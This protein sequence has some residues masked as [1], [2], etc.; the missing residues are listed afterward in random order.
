MQHTLHNRYRSNYDEWAEGGVAAIQSLTIVGH[1]NTDVP[2]QAS[3]DDVREESKYISDG[4]PGVFADSLVRQRE[5]ILSLVAVDKQT[6][7]SRRCERG[8][9]YRVWDRGRAY[10]RASRR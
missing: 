6:C 2:I 5:G 3:A 7:T 4:L 8:P 10:R 9:G 1:L